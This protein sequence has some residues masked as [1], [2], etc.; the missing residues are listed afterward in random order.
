M[1]LNRRRFRVA[2]RPRVRSQR[3][4]QAAALL[5]TLA[6][7][8]GA[9]WVVKNAPRREW[10]SSDLIGKLPI[11]DIFKVQTITIVGAPEQLAAAA[12]RLLDRPA[13][14]VWG[15]RSPYAAARRAKAQLTSLRQV[16]VRRDWF[17][18]D[19]RFELELHSPIAAVTRRGAPAGWLSDTGAVMTAPAG[20]F[21]EEARPVVEL[22]SAPASDYFALAEF[23][24]TATQE[25]MMPAPLSKVAYVSADD[26][27]EM[28]LSDG[29]RIQWGNLNWTEHKLA[30]LRQVA[31]DAA[32]RLGRGFV[33]DLRYFDEG[34]VLVRGL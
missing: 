10:K 3:R 13:G 2:L 26:G 27:W 14:T 23:L 6:L 22:G 9:W 29:T 31:A 11:P 18:R 1:R 8:G 15:F 21:P 34:K 19:V 20:L 30:R 25:Q 5:M 16:R 32:A 24:K 33:A 4:A 7:G 28:T 17:K 12:H